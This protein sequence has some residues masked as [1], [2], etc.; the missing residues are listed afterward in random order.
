MMKKQLLILIL[1][2]GVCLVNAQGISGRFS[3]I[4]R[5]G[6]TVA[7]TTDTKAATGRNNA[8]IDSRY[9]GGFIAGLDIE[10]TVLEQ[11]GIALGA[12]YATEGSRFPDIDVFGKQPKS[13]G[14]HDWHTDLHYVNVPLTANYYFLP[15]LAVKAGIQ[16][17]FLLDAK[18]KFQRTEITTDKTGAKQYGA[19]EEH[20][21]SLKDKFRHT[22]FSIPIGFSYEYMN[23]ILDARYNFGL[24]RI[25]TG[26]LSNTVH[27]KN[28]FL[29]FTVGYRFG[30]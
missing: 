17:G 13:A 24:T 30:L 26:E 10:Y 12:C 29:T 25:H 4:P 1:L 16:F 2:S 21:N 9:R 28:R 27:S 3:I 14:Y 22:D 5:L 18:E 11:I 19:T 6:G 8:S 7:N 20:R 15:G 23:V